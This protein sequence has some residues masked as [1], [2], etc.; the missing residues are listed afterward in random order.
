MIAYYLDVQDCI[1]SP[2]NTFYAMSS[3]DSGNNVDWQFPGAVVEMQYIDIQ[4]CDGGFLDSSLNL[5][6]WFGTKDSVDRGNNTNWIF[7][8]QYNVVYSPSNF[9]GFF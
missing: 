7:D 2:A 1:A 3:A 5:V 6:Y 4:D 8:R 9:L